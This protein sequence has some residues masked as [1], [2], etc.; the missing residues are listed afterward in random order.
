[1]FNY[2]YQ[3]TYP[4]KINVVYSNLDLKEDLI[5]RPKYLSLCHADQRY[6]QGNR[7]IGVLKKKLPMALIHE[8]CGEVVYDKSNTYKKG[9]Y[10]VF[11]PNVEGIKRTD[12]NY[13]NYTKNGKFLSSGCDGFM[14]ELVNI[15]KERVVPFDNKIVSPKI[16]STTEFISVCVHIADRLTNSKPITKKNI[17]VWGDGSLSYTMCNVLSKLLPESNIVVIGKHLDKMSN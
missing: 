17:G 11:I 8:A 9:Q 6:Y 14:R 7:D 1:M 12:E 3:L 15:S 4:K 2:I 5:V 13:E 10:V 16:A